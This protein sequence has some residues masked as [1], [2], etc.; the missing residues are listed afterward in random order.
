MTRS[1]PFG[2]IP[3]GI[4]QTVSRGPL[5][6]TVAM[7]LAVALWSPDLL[8]LPFKPAFI[9]TLPV[10]LCLGLMLWWPEAALPLALFALP[11]VNIHFEVGL[12]DKT[13]SFD[14]VMLLTL[15][16]SWAVRRVYLRRWRLPRDP[17]LSLWWIWLAIQGITLAVARTDA[18]NQFWYLSE[19]V[20]YLLFFLLC[21]DVLRDQAT[22]RAVIQ[23]IMASGWAVALLGMAERVSHL[24]VGADVLYLTYPS[25]GKW[26]AEFGSTIGHP[27][28]YSAFQVLSIPFTAWAIREAR[29]RWRW[30][31]AGILVVQCGSVFVAKSIGGVV[32]L[33]VAAWVGCWWTGKR[34][35]R[36]F[37]PVAA[38]V[39]VVAIL[40]LVQA[41]DPKGVDRSALVRTHILRVAS[42]LFVERPFFGHGLGSFTR[43]F[44][45]YELVY[46]RERLVGDLGK[47]R[48]FP[49]SVSSHNWFLRLAVEGGLASLLTFLGLI[50]WVMASRWY[51][52]RSPPT[53]QEAQPDTPHLAGRSLRVALAAALIG[54]V[55][56]AFTDEL[57]AYSKIVLIFW[58]LTA[59]GVSLD[60]RSRVLQGPAAR[61]GPRASSRTFPRGK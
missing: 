57:F 37:G 29:G 53:E 34:S 44:P 14:K 11:L 27:N 31:F 47:W 59:V 25:T 60:M 1:L 58:A 18:G 45:D 23:A 56:Q 40:W 51:S 26:A 17:I 42:H 52:L 28:F 30:F 21:L 16:G 5:V 10:A 41:R 20:A 13:V 38:A 35:W 8:S 15:L 36:V 22:V 61:P 3:S 24:L 2:E 9:L 43:V 6:V 32:G 19:Q 50:A 55:V 48:D 39:G 49:R 33:A 4:R 54:F 7:A 12:P 46:G